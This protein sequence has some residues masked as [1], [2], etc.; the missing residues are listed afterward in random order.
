MKRVGLVVT[1]WRAGARKSVFWWVAARNSGFACDQRTT[2]DTTSA[3]TQTHSAKTA[4]FQRFSPNG[5]ALWRPHHHEPRPRRRQS[6][7][8][9]PCKGATRR[10]HADRALRMAQNPHRSGGCRRAW[11]PGGPGRGAG[12]GDGARPRQ[13]SHVISDGHFLRPPKNVAIPTR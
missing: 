10:R 11:R 3:I 7:G 13:I 12:G 6:G 1:L 2:T 5:S 8:I 9:T 4:W